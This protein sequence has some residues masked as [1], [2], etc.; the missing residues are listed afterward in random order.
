[1]RR[2][3]GPDRL[4]SGSA[5]RRLR[6]TFQAQMLRYDVGSGL[7][8]DLNCSSPEMAARGPPLV[9]VAAEVAQ[10]YQDAEAAGW[11]QGLVDSDAHLGFSFRVGGSGETGVG[12]GELREIDTDAVATGVLDQALQPSIIPCA[13]ELREQ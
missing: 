8:F 5:K 10:Q 6:W 2:R 12:R 11:R 4:L 1:M 3:R 7:G 13:L 9:L